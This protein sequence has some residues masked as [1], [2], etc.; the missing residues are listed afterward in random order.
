MAGKS[1]GILGGTFDPIHNGHLKI[2]EA[3]FERMELE[4]I[5]FIPAYVPPHKLGLDFAPA[6]SRFAMTQLAVAEKPH[7]S[8]SDMELRRT[9]VSYTIDTLRELHVLHPEDKLYFIIGADSVAQLHT[10][11]NI[12]EMLELTTFVAVW[13]PGYEGVLDVAARHLGEGVREHIIMLDTPEYDI[14]STEIRSCIREGKSL[15]GLV[16]TAVEKYIYEHGLYGL[17]EVGEGK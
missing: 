6:E 9:G 15:A 11:H 1:L 3:V 14:S 12:E 8:V 2:A 10:W 17:S 13:R 16:P 4:Q 7:F 5:I